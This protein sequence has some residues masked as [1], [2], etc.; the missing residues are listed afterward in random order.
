MHQQPA[1]DDEAEATVDQIIAAEGGDARAAVRALIARNWA[2]EMELARL[3]NAV[4]RGYLRSR[5][6][7]ADNRDPL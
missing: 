7:T 3:R 6:A 1:A 2:A 5:S 4:S